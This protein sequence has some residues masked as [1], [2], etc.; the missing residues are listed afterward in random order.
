MNF[1]WS[2]HD[3][4]AEIAVRDYFSVKSPVFPFNKFRG[5]DTILGPEMRSTGEVMGISTIMV[6]RLRKRNWPLGRNLPRKG[7]V[8][9]SVN[10]RDK[11]HIG[12][13]GKELVPAGIQNRC[14]A[15]HLR[16]DARLRRSVRG[17]VSR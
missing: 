17:S 13:L 16:G 12:P 6:R 9:M 10:D 11:R 14:H 2:H 1:R 4:V 7:T 3:G 15:R 5:V 8:F